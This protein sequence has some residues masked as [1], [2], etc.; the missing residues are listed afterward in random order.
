MDLHVDICMNIFNSN[1]IFYIHTLTEIF[2]KCK[3]KYHRVI[4]YYAK[5]I[6]T[7]HIKTLFVTHN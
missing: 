4:V 6:S 7:N 2:L 5:R 1:I 3:T